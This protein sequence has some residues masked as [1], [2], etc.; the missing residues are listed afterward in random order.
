MGFY[1]HRCMVTGV[2]LKGADTVLVLLRQLDDVYV[3]F[4]LPITGN[5]NRLG[6]IDGIDEDANTEA[7]LRYFLDQLDRG[8]FV[9]DADYLRVEGYYPIEDIERLLACC[10]RNMTDGEGRAVLGGQSVVYALI[11]RA[12]WNGISRASRST[13]ASP[14]A[15][16]SRLFKAVPFAA[17]IYP[18]DLAPFERHLREL[19][20]VAAILKGRA[21]PWAPPADPDQQYPEEMRRYLA[22]ARQMFADSP[23]VLEALGD[24]EREVADLLAD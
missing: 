16:F 2:G 15:L 21:I 22:E 17:E 19:A 8:G 13:Q 7:V 20:A 24:Y 4:A 1:D 5:Y 9:V 6:C 18:G 14:A 12:V 23:V 11:A 10:E 3:P